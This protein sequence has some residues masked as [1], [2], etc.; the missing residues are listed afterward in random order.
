MGETTFNAAPGTPEFEKASGW[1]GAVN[2]MYN[3]VTIFAAP[4][5]DLRRSRSR[6]RLIRFRSTHP[7]IRR[8]VQPVRR[9][10]STPCTDR[11]RRWPSGTV[12]DMSVT[13]VDDPT[14]SRFEARV[15]G[16]LVGVSVYELTSDTIVFLHTNVDERYEGQG[17]GSEIAR[18]ALDDARARGLYVRPLCP[19]IRD[20]MKRH[21]EYDDLIRAAG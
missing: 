16:V 12:V 6:F 13:V 8:P 2:G 1:V 4:L 21:P 17:V 9:R 19:F 10:R 11:K 15:D 14:E 18:S 20:W 5:A 7:S 3:L